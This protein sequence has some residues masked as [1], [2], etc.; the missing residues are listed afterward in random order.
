MTTTSH[1]FPLPVDG[2]TVSVGNQPVV[3]TLIGPDSEAYDT[4]RQAWNLDVDQRPACVG[5]ARSVEDVQ[6]A[7]AYA[8]DHGLTVA[9]QSTGHLSQ[10]LPSLER[11]LLLKLALH[12]GPVEVAPCARVARIKAGARWDDV[13]RAVA[14]HGLAAMHGSSP[15][16]GV[17]GY[18][19]GGGLSFYGRR[20]GLAVN[21][22][23]A[24]EV[25]TP[26][27]VLRRVDADHEP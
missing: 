14:P 4:A 24:F 15:S 5:L 10:T 18:L 12:D 13:V 6:A 22:V 11:T 16:V 7:V 17:I 26:D 1:S 8:R 20:H 3:P 9:T 21:H 19:L 25:V 23:R 2:P 27:G